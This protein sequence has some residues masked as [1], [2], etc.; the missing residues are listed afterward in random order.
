[1]TSFGK[2]SNPTAR[3]QALMSTGV[4]PCRTVAVYTFRGN[5]GTL[6]RRVRKAL[7][8]EVHGL[9]PGPTPRECLL[10]AG[11]TGVSTDSGNAIYGFHPDFGI[12]PIWQAMQRLRNGDAFPGVVVDDTRVFAAARATRLRVQAFDV[13]LPEP[14]FQDVERK[15]V[16]ERKQSRYTYGFP[17]GDGD[18][19][20][21]TWLE[22]LALPLL[23]GSMDEF[24]A[25]PG[26]SN[27]P[28]RRVGQC[29]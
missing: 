26:F 11:H 27:Y 24:T 6:G 18:C 2:D 15:L 12:L 1:M 5:R 9:G 8:D 13:I 23:S 25:L 17:N 3:E 20:C 7:D 16:A 28:S 10:Y 4:P 19:N 22:R 21:T 29:L 14:D